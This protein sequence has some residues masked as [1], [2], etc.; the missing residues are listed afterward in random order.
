[1]LPPCPRVASDSRPSPAADPAP[2][3]FR[4]LAR[5]REQERGRTGAVGSLSV[6]TRAIR[7]SDEERLR[8][9]D[10]ERLIS[11]DDMEEDERPLIDI[12]RGARYTL[13]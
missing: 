3:P 5:R 13:R 4:H 12:V 2:L 11:L 8:F 1:M 7:I 6:A 9:L 10:E